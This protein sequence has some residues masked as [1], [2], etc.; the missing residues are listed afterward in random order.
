MKINYGIV[1][2]L[3]DQQKDIIHFCGYED[4]PTLNDVKSLTMELMTDEEFELC[5]HMDN[6]IFREATD[7]EIKGLYA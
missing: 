2:C 3:P 1:V 5:D 4:I 6:L 7:E